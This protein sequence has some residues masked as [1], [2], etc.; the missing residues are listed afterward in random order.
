MSIF[1]AA[2]LQRRAF[3][4][5]AALVAAVGQNYHASLNRPAH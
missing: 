3:S 2:A 5:V 1:D 4:S